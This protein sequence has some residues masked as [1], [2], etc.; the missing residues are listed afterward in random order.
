MKQFIKR[1]IDFYET[2]NNSTSL[3][4]LMNGIERTK[5]LGLQIKI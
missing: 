5:S 1:K 3:K 4:R 2:F